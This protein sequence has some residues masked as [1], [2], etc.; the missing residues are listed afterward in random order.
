MIFGSTST[1][2]PLRSIVAEELATRARCS[3]HE[4]I[5]RAYERRATRVLVCGAL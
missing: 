1:G 5:K 3:E 2:A 4:A